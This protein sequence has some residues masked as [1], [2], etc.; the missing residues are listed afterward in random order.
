M[1]NVPIEISIYHTWILCC[2][3]RFETNPAV[4]I[5]GTEMFLKVEALLYSFAAG[6]LWLHTAMP[7]G[8]NQPLAYIEMY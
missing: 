2:K 8:G 7:R 4:R 3:G 5:G 6:R 1:I